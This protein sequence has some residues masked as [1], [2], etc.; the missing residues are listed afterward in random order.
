MVIAASLSSCQFDG[1]VDARNP[2]VEELDALDV[3]WGLAARKSR[4]GPRRTF[5]YVD[6]SPSSVSAAPAPVTPAPARETINTEPPAS[7]NPE[8]PAAAPAVVVPSNLR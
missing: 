2:T 5:Q 6:P 4:G 3:Q 8:P 1:K 7:F